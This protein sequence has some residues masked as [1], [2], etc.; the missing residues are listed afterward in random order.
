M[1]DR[2]FAP[3]FRIEPHQNDLALALDGA[4]QLGMALPAAAPAQQLFSACTAQG[5]ARWDNSG[6]VKAIEDLAG[7][8]IVSERRESK[9][10]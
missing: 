2:S 1:L 8:K 9:A 10:A 5:G 7:C 3:G 6:L 4:R